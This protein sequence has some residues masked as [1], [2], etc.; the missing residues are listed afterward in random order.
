MWAVAGLIGAVHGRPAAAD[1]NRPTK[2][3]FRIHRAIHAPAL[4]GFL[5]GQPDPATEPITD[6][7][8]RQPRD[9]APAS[10]PTAVYLSYDPNNLYAIFVCADDPTL[11][12]AHM[13]RR[14]SISNDDS[15]GISI[16]THH[17][18]RRAYMFFANPL[19]VQLD[20]ITTEGQPDD[21]SFDTV[22][23]SEGR[24]TA[25]GYVVRFTIP[26]KSLRFR[27]E[28]TTWG[29]AL[30][31]HITRN[32]EYSTWP[33]ITDRIEAYVPQFGDLEGIEEETGHRNFELIPYGVAGAGRYLGNDGQ[34]RGS[35]DL[36]GG[37]DAKLVLR[38]TLTLDATFNPDFSQ[39]ES[40]E[41]QV[42]VNQRY[43]VYFPERRPFFVENAGFFETPETLFFS[44]RIIDPQFGARLTGTIG[45]WSL[46]ILAADDRA[47]G[48]LDGSGA[49]A[50]I[51][52]ARLQRNVGH[53]STFGI[54]LTSRDEASGSD[55]V[56]SA[57]TRL[58]LSANWVL[59]AQ[60]ALSANR[61]ETL[62][63]HTGTAWFAEIRHTGRHLQYYTDYRDRSA[64]FRADLGFIPR[65]D[66]RQ[67]RNSLDYRWR[68]ENGSLVSFGPS[69][70]TITTWDHA[71]RLQDSTVETPFWF[72]FKG[73]SSVMVSRSQGYEWYLG[74]GFRKSVNTVYLSSD[75][76]RWM[77]MTAYFSK[78][79]S[80]NYDPAS[81]LTPQ[82][83]KSIES[84]LELTFRPT[85]RARL[86]ETYF[87]TRLG[88]PGAAVFNDHLLRSKLNYQLTRALSVRVILDY[89]AVLPNRSLASLERT[90]RLTTDFLLSYLV[91]PGTAFYIGYTDRRENLLL[92]YHAVPGL[93]RGGGPSTLSGGQLFAKINYLLR[94]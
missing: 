43:E 49:R 32:N 39:V 25:H 56:F 44:R 78:G 73:P 42:T 6:L 74:H 7:R 15:V 69:L 85:S 47:P 77:G 21:Y 72:N 1:T 45:A 27:K 18:G 26:F 2:P 64:E 58:K 63:G 5:T 9:G 70:K 12:R 59:S 14:E 90:K 89:N 61:R 87:Y 67:V 36:R 16:D 83:G 30:T 33:Y 20:G 57:D 13:G 62:P 84:S 75:R 76:W 24:L 29:I 94:F 17:Q 10:Q 38:D 80:L 50:R 34:Y 35:H 46:G 19:G 37:M 54:L 92:D 8:Q 86:D 31:R 91:H 22:W 52:V 40:D 71:G 11:V 93:F 51:G 82:A 4:E 41:P 23:Q 55:Q 48:A 88:V 53:E 65:V 3:V 68:P 60:A 28:Q 66:I 81:G 79:R